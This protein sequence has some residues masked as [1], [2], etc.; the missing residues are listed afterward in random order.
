MSA[1][2]E[3]STSA[4]ATAEART[5]IVSAMPEETAAILARCA[6]DERRTVDGCRIAVG[7]LGRAPVVI[8]Q[9]GEGR[10]LARAGLTAL[11]DHYTVGQVIVVGVSGGLSPSLEPGTLIVGHDLY[12]ADGIA[13]APD[14]ALLERLERG[15]HAR[16]ARLLTTETLLCTREDKSAALAGLGGDGPAAVDLESSVYARVAAERKIP[17]VVL[18]AVSDAADEEMPF[19]LNAC[20]DE[21]GRIHRGRVFARAMRRPGSIGVLWNLQKRVTR[22]AIDLARAVEGLLEG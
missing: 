10:R 4:T 11:L 15:A 18:R 2:P 17:F 22:C 3:V 19:D 20:R 21:T 5:A 8:A 6:I 1:W 9:T 16:A 12:D 7:R 14:R 13:P